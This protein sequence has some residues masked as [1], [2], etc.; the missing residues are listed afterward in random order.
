MVKSKTWLTLTFPFSN[1]LVIFSHSA[2]SIYMLKGHGVDRH[3]EY[4]HLLNFKA[5]NTKLYVDIYRTKKPDLIRA[6]SWFY[7][8]EKRNDGFY[9]KFAECTLAQV[10]NE[11][12]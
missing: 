9:R 11:K 3:K 4:V 8:F 1:S 7:Q 10:I 5:K 6:Y 12:I 2:F